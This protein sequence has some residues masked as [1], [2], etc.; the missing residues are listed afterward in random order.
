MS[1]N[2]SSVSWFGQPN[3]GLLGLRVIFEVVF[4]IRGVLTAAGRPES[5]YIGDWRIYVLGQSLS[6]NCQTLDG[7]TEFT[8]SSL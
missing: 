4:L 2:E 8:L 3:W 5:D 1:G 6:L 7:T